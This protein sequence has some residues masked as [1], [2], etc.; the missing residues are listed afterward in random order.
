[1]K[2]ADGL[3]VA[4]GVLPDRNGAIDWLEFPSFRLA[5][6]LKFGNTERQAPLT[7][8]GMAIPGKQLLLLPEDEPSRVFLFALNR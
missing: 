7:R 5:R 6:R 4:S 8:E 1:M 2:F 3:L